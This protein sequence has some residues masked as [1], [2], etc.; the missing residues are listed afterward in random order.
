MENSMEATKKAKNRS[1][2]LSNNT[3]PRDV[4]QGI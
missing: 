1:T 4:S 2:I 3:T